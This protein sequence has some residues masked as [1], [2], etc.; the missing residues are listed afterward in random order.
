MLYY[1]FIKSHSQV[2]DPEPKDPLVWTV[3]N[4]LVIK[5]SGFAEIVIFFLFWKTDTVCIT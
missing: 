3:R 4:I 5:L 1:T 2:S